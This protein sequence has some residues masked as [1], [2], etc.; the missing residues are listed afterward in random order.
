[1]QALQEPCASFAH[2][3]KVARA[4]ASF[5]KAFAS[6]A[7]AFASFAKPF[8]SFARAFASFTITLAC[9]RVCFLINSSE[10]TIA[11]TIFACCSRFNRCN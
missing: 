10:K 4:S 7:K 6:F 2:P 1:L 11:A 8:A 9:L 3:L 5:A